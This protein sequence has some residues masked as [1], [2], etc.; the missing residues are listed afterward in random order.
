M[1]FCLPGPK[2]VFLDRF[3]R[4][5]ILNNRGKL[6]KCVN[7]DYFYIDCVSREARPVRAQRGESLLFFFGTMLD[8]DLDA[9]RP[10]KPSFN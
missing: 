6:I 8:H 2:K 1:F 9:Q 5:L 4:L 7:N 10:Q 3:Y